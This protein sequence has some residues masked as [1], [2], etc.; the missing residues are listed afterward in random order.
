VKKILIVA[1]LEESCCATP[2]GLELAHRL[3]RAVD[4]VAFTWVSLKS[5]GGTGRDQAEV[6]RKLLDERHREVQ[7]RIDRYRRPGQEVGLQV[8]WHKNIE[9]WI[10]SECARGRYAGVVKTGSRTGT[11]VHTSTD[12]HLL[13]ECPVPVLLVA[14]KRWHR[15]RPVLAA[16][17]LASGSRVKQALNDKVLGVAGSLAEG[18]GVEL[19]VITAIAVPT[20]LAD[21]DLVEPDA[22]ERKARRDMQPRIDKLSAAHGVPPQAFVSKRGPVEKVIVSCA[23]RERAQIVVMGTVARKGVKA[24][25]L[26][27]TAEQVLRALNTDVLALKP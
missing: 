2:R 10:C 11:L 16:L 24:R 18:L 7:S 1:D 17:D 25:L 8:V 3:G 21:L 6:R 15:T 26:G 9:R 4:V 12:W 27:N 19:R 22:Y 14:R 20:L 23:A 5:L 13:R